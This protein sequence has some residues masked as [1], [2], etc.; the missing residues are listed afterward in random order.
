MA[1]LRD[2][3]ARWTG[4]T[5]ARRAGAWGEDRAGWGAGAD[6]G[7]VAGV[8]GAR[9][10]PGARAQR[11]RTMMSTESWGAAEAISFHSGGGFLDLGRGFLDLAGLR[12]LRAGCAREGEPISRRAAMEGAGAAE[13]ARRG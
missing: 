8:K 1:S 10:G 6:G 11:T 12:D 3:K 7:A 2:L 13:G 5:K 4:L 9:E